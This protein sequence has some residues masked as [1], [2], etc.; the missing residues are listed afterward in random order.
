MGH[1][2]RFGAKVV[3]LRKGQN[4]KLSPKGE[5]WRMCGYSP[6]QKG[7]RLLF[8]RS[9]KLIIRRDCQFVGERR[10]EVDIFDEFDQEN[11]VVEEKVKCREHLPRACK[12]Q[13]SVP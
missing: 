7:Y 10:E 8:P 6:T 12:R 4:N 1:L 11:D 9:G 3:P 5:S 13:V 2:Q